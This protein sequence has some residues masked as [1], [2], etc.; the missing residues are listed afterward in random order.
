MRDAYERIKHELTNSPVLLL[1]EFE[2]PFKFYMDSAC[3]QGLGASMH[4][5][6]IVDGEPREGANRKL[7]NKYG[8]LQHIEELKH[9]W[10]TINIDWVTGIVPGGK[11]SFNSFLVI[12]YRY[13]NILRCLACHKEDTA[14]DTAFLFCNN[15]ISTCGVPK[16]IM[17]NRDPKF[18]SE[19]WTN[20]YE[21]RGTK[22]AF[23]I[24]CHPQTDGLAEWMIHKMEDIIQRFCAYCLEYDSN[25]GYTH[26]WLTLLPAVQ[27]AYNTSQNPA[28]GKSPSLVEKG[29]NPLLPVVHLKTN[30]LNIHLTAEDFHNMWKRGCDMASKCIAEA[31]EHKKQSYYK[32]HMEPYFK[33]GDPVL[34]STLNFN[35]L[36]EQRKSGTNF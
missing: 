27:L 26:D 30:F 1:P 32:T 19:V 15:I 23:S 35:N 14:M 4:Q 16:I 2:L 31:K 24:A 29:W 6:Q 34:V 33:E 18:P 5:R 28:T 21:M 11:E 25:E 9:P 8:V 20:L 10:E 7:G 17:S 13:S 36:K 3:S 22:I 12:I